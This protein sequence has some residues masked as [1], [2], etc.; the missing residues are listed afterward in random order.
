MLYENWDKELVDLWHVEQVEDLE[1]VVEQLSV[2]SPPPSKVLKVADKDE[3]SLKH[4]GID[5]FTL[6]IFVCENRD[7]LCSN[8]IV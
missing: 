2:L 7:Q 5:N 3:H 6:E 8:L 4:V 1:K